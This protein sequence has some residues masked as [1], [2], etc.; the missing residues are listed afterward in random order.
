[1][2]WFN[3]RKRTSVDIEEI[4]LDASNLPAFNKGRLEGRMELPVTR[5]NVYLIGLLFILI[6]AGFFYQLYQLQI[7]RG[8]ELYLTSENNSINQSVIIAERGVLY[9]RNDEMLAWNEYGKNGDYSFP[10]RAYTHS[11]TRAA[12]WLRQLPTKRLTWFLLSD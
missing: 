2:H 11:R 8:A 6:A 5:R 7:V 10:M 1:M 9:D 12:H 4:F 3:R